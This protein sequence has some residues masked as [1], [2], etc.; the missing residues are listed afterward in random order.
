MEG[1]EQDVEANEDGDGEPADGEFGL[2]GQRKS[3]QQ[4]TKV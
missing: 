1:E 3:K 2:P 4:K